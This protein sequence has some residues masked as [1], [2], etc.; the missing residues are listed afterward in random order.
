MSLANNIYKFTPFAL[1]HGGTQTDARNLTSRDAFVLYASEFLNYVKPVMS[2]TSRYMEFLSDRY[3]EK[4][5]GLTFRG[6]DI[7]KFLRN[8]DRNH[9]GV[10]NGY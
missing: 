8:H 10:P 4:E 2:V 6:V 3:N 1:E 9:K 7:Y 5:G